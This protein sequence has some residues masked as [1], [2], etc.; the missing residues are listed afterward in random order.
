MVTENPGDMVTE[1]PVDTEGQ[2]DDKT[3]EDKKL[4][5]RSHNQEHILYTAPTGK[6]A[7]LL[8]RRANT[9]GYTLHQVI[10]S[11]RRFVSESKKNPEENM[12]WRFCSKS[13]LVVDECSLVSVKTFSTLLKILM[14]NARLSRIILLGDIRQLPSIEPGNFLSD[15]FTSLI[16]RG[17]A[18]ELK[19]NH[20]AESQLIVDNAT[21]ISLRKYPIMD[22]ERNFKFHRV[23]E[24]VQD[25]NDFTD[26]GMV[27]LFT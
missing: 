17:C 12:T 7:N 6:A 25:K 8:G 15:V 27:I 4:N 20:R 18:I 21:R 24:D 9:T 22:P 14:E 16:T 11:Y 26:S 19:T 23:P 3:S 2:S 1:N 10:W 13:I 5:I